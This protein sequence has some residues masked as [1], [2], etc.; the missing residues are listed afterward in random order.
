M[1]YKIS[2]APL[3]LKEYG[4]NIQSMVDYAKTIED[5]RQR[6]KVIHEIVRIMTN[7]NPS[8]KDLPDYQQKLWDH[9]FLIADFDLD[10][11]SPFPIPDKEKV[12]FQKPVK[13][14]YSKN[15][16]AYKQYGTNV[17]LMIKKAIDM[18]EGEKKRAYVNIIANTMKQFLRNMDRE[19]MQEEAIIRH[20]HDI[21]K[22]KLVIN[23]SDISLFKGMQLK[24]QPRNQIETGHHKKKR[25]NSGR[26]NS[27]RK[28]SK[29]K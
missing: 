11:D 5:K 29:R 20:I 14:P 18:P 25:K 23:P 22:G 6:T 26:K 19:G 10:V 3:R 15:K 7:L 17:E 27:G 16:P 8:I 9:L 13:I 12:L 4:R 2:D 21:S 1:K 24:N 28:N